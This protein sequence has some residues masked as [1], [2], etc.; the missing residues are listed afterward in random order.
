MK[1]NWLEPAV[2][3]LSLAATAN[4]NQPDMPPDGAFGDLFEDGIGKECDRC[5]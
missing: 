5:S 2:M 3:E 1:K 4:T